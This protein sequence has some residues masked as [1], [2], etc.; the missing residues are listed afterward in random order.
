VP[1]DL[2]TPWLVIGGILLAVVALLG[3]VVGT[4]RSALRRG[5]RTRALPG[6]STRTTTGGTTDTGDGGGTALL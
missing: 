5:R 4:R 3:L 2:T 6:D 1:V